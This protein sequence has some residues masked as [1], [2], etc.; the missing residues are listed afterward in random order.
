MGPFRKRL[1][2]QHRSTISVKC[3]RCNQ[4]QSFRGHL[5]TFPPNKSQPNA[6]KSPQHKP[7]FVCY[8]ILDIE[9]IPMP[10]L[11]SGSCN[12]WTLS[13]QRSVVVGA[14]CICLALPWSQTHYIREPSPCIHTHSSHLNGSIDPRRAK[15][16]ELGE[17]RVV[18]R[19]LGIFNV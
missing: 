15:E 17:K 10:M 8:P 19:C 9:N 18:S 7:F 11:H 4:R 12:C 13:K 16:E 1:R 3:D 5:M 14:L 2:L 6:D